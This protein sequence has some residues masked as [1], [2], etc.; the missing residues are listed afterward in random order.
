MAVIKFN[1]E[2][3]KWLFLDLGSKGVRRF[4]G[5]PEEV[6]N[7]WTSQLTLCLLNCIL[8]SLFL[9]RVSGFTAAKEHKR[10]KLRLKGEG[11]RGACFG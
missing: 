10:K 3:T 7:L 4:E 5:E 11:R 2:I 9:E 1:Q 6:E 8:K